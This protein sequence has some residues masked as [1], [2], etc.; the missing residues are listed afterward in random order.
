MLVPPLTEEDTPLEF[1]V[2]VLVVAVFGISYYIS[3][4]L[5]PWVKCSK[6]HGEAR[7][8][9]WFFGYA[10]HFCPK[11]NGTGHQLRFGRKLFGMGP[12]AD[13]G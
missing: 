4:L 3:L 10:H 7:P 8:R 6:C 1:F 13:D 9:G 11:C 2:P 12:P 5:N